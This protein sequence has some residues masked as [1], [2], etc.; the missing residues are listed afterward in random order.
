M[1]FERIF[2]K[3][4]L[5]GEWVGKEQKVLRK[6]RPICFTTSSGMCASSTSILWAQKSGS[7]G[8]TNRSNTFF[9]F[10]GQPEPD[11]GANFC[12]ISSPRPYPLFGWN[13]SI[14]RTRRCVHLLSFKAYHLRPHLCHPPRRGGYC[15][16]ALLTSGPLP[17]LHPT[18]SDNR[19]AGVAEGNVQLVKE[20]TTLPH[21]KTES[22][23]QYTAPP[24]KSRPASYTGTPDPTVSAPTKTFFTTLTMAPSTTNPQTFSLYDIAVHT[25]TNQQV[26]IIALLQYASNRHYEAITL[27]HDSTYFLEGQN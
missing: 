1:P 20:E 4:R 18:P 27:P 10:C 8:K 3:D 9:S 2:K 24:P 25:K 19:H 12:S 26:I 22:T 16:T 17:P 11:A 14:I 6:L 5:R 23:P 21:I 13:Q 15:L 7:I